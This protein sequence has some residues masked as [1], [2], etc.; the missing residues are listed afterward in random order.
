MK[1]YIVFQDNTFKEITD[2]QYNDI[3]DDSNTDVI[4]HELDGSFYKFTD[5]KKILTEDD[6]REQYPSKSNSGGYQPYSELPPISP[7]EII[8]S[9]KDTKNIQAMIR[10]FKRVNPNPTTEG[11]RRL[12]KAMED[13]LVELE[14]KLSTSTN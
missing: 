13:K 8:A 6:F 4:G 2:K 7:F 1:Y 11:A 12:L 10:G 5:M 14:K 9:V 3:L